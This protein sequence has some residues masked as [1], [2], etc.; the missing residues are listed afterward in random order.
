MEF[1]TLEQIKKHLNIDADFTED[2]NYLLALGDVAEQVVKMHVDDNLQ[3]LAANNGGDLPAPLLHAMLLHI[4]SL[5]QSRETNSLS[6]LTTV[7]FA[8]DYMLSL[9]KNY[10]S[11]NPN[12][13]DSNTNT[14][15]V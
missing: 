11:T 4:G 7:P 12:N 14:C 6:S 3:L 10:K 1:L 15:G 13:N 9:Y 2:D 5:Y 8:Y